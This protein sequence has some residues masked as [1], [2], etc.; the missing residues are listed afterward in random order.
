MP[1]SVNDR[2]PVSLSHG[3]YHYSYASLI[4]VV[5]ML[6]TSYLIGRV[7]FHYCLWRDD[8]YKYIASSQNMKIN[9]R[10]TLKAELKYHPISVVI[11]LGVTTVFYIG[12]AIRNL[13]FGY[14]SSD[15]STFEHEFVGNSLW[16]TIVTMTTVGYGDLY[17]QT[18]LGR[19]FAVGSFL[20][21]N[22]FASFITVILATKADFTDQEY[23]AYTMIKK[24]AKVEKVEDKAADV[25]RSALFL[26]R[27]RRNKEFRNYTDVYKHYTDLSKGI[28]SFQHQKTIADRQKLPISTILTNMIPKH[29]QDCKEIKVVIDNCPSMVQRLKTLTDSKCMP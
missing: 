4:N 7:Y 15:G 14:T 22:F 11:I 6:K 29:K 10:F 25:I 3:T 27:S 9:I 28:K 17:P 8:D 5:S 19:S 2:L 24:L 20:F 21:G 26:R 23:K 18:H 12:F 16:M 1:P 13:E